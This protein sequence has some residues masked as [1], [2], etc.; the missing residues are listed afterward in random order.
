MTDAQPTVHRRKLGQAL[1]GL[2]E[3]KGLS[4]TEAANRLDMP[5]SAL[6]KIENG[7]QRVPAVSLAGY[8]ELYGCAGTPRAAQIRQIATMAAKG[9]RSNLL[10][11]FA[12]VVHDSFA[13]YL[14]AEALATKIDTYNLI[15]PGL[16]Q[17]EAYAQ[18]LVERSRKWHSKKDVATYVDLRMARQDAL[19]RDPPLQVWCV[20]DEAALRR[21]VGGSQIIRDQLQHLVDFTE[22][23]PNVAIQVLP[24]SIGSH[25]GIDG[26]FHVLHFPAG[27]P[28]VVVEP[29]T[30][31]L[32]L[33][34]ELD[35]E[36]YM[37]A[38]NYLRADSLD[39]T[40][41]R[42]FILDVIKDYS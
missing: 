1:K 8:F 35:V 31:C 23:H 17:T 25:A 28:V 4:L 39:V 36:R 33:E 6:S 29:M 27:P 26:P 34:E 19:R 5:K 16:L 18:A 15:I 40:N 13:Q 37:T 30:S 2:R 14:N 41:S 42:Q 10:D 20:L 3:A 21:R 9:K 24:F 7:R 22:E 32:Y 38:Y 12:D 11:R